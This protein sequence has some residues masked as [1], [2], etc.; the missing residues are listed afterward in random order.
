MTDMRWHILRTLLHKEVLRHL[1]NRGGLVLVLLLVVASMLLSFFGHGDVGAGGFAPSV[2]RCY[3]DYWQDGDLVEHL[4]RNVPRDLAGHVRFRPAREVPT[5]RTGKLLYVQNTGA[6]Q[7]RPPEGDGRGGYKVCFWHPGSDGSALAPFEVWFWKETARFYQ[8]RALPYAPAAGTAPGSGDA[9]GAPAAGEEGG[10]TS[11]RSELEGGLDTRSGLATS[12]VLFGLFFVCVYLLPSLTCEERERGV[13]LAQALSPASPREILAAKFL[14]YPVL[15]AALGAVLAGTYQPRVLTQAFFWLTLL[16]SVVGSM[17]IGLTIASVARTQRAA[18]LGALCYMMAV[19]LLQLVCQ[20]G[21]IPGLP[22]LAL[23]YHCSRLL[24]ASLKEVVFG[25]HYGHLAG[26][27]A[28][29][30]AWTGL[31]AVLFRRQGWQ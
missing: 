12:L 3:V 1:A 2:Q 10:L 18:G 9:A 11:E 24:H 27:A 21:G 20:Q 31:A 15:G 4:R 23:E 30:C 25:Y 13:L 8:L 17:G 5:D 26:A 16:V 29:A 14:F 7:I 28:L 19:A 6:I 22:Y